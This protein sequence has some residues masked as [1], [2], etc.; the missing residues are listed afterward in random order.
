[1]IRQLVDLPTELERHLVFLIVDRCAGV[2]AD[3]ERL[4]PLEYER[5]RVFHRLGSYHV[6]VDLSTPVPR[7]L[8][9]FKYV[10]I[11]VVKGDAA[12]AV[13]ECA[14]AVVEATWYAMCTSAVGM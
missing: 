6:P 4:I 3:V 1:M 12:V 7:P 14:E 13:S 10:F 9:V 11:R 8:K 5:H 2:R